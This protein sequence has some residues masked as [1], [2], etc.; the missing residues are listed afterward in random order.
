MIYGM[1]LSATG[2]QTASHQQDVLANNLANAETSGF[3]RSMTLLKQRD[4][5]AKAMHAAGLRH[6]LQD[7]IGGGHLLSPTSIDFSQGGIEDTGNPFDLAVRGEGFLGVRVGQETRLTRAGELMINNQG[8]LV[9]AQGFQVVND[10]K[11]PISLTGYAQGELTIYEDGSIKRGQDLVAKIGL[12]DSTDKKALKNLG[13][14][15]LA[16]TGDEAKM[17]PATGSLLSGYVERANVEPAVE[18]TRLMETQRQL[19]ANANMIKF[20][21]TTLG[22]LVNEVGKI[23]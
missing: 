4:V 3:K 10:Q 13:E 23:S 11:Q 18:I 5:E 8:Q 12:F 7:N 9:N 21:D 14:N 6:P 2:V 1:Y 17:V 19:E 15:L 22:R 16:I 20:Q